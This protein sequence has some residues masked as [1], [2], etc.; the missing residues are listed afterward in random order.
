MS[1][2]LF[3]FFLNDIEQNLQEHTLYLIQKRGCKGLLINSSIL[4]KKEI[5]CSYWKN[6]GDDL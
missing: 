4:Q 6:Q 5:N 2:I 3:S 1:P